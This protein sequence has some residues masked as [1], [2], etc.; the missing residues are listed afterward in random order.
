[1]T[2]TT[3]IRELKEKTGSTIKD[4]VAA[5][6]NCNDD[7]DKAYAWLDE[8]GLIPKHKEVITGLVYVAASSP[9]QGDPFDRCAMIELTCVEDMTKDSEDF[10]LLVLSISH[11][12]LQSQLLGSDEVASIS[13]QDCLMESVRSNGQTMTVKEAMET[14]SRDHSDRVKLRRASGIQVHKPNIFVKYYNYEN[15]ISSIVVLESQG[16]PSDIRPV[17]DL[18]REITRVVVMK[19]DSESNL[20][21]M[22][23]LSGGTVQAAID[24]CSE[25]VKS[26]L[27]ITYLRYEIGEDIK[28]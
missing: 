17:S 8:H 5:L 15:S 10:Q 1:M 4:C 2:N 3:T 16:Q 27:T 9:T 18:A 26:P 25:T 19:T 11:A 6:K 14:F 13:I 20:L 23:M 28:E 12:I 22:E 7:I 24:R 21:N